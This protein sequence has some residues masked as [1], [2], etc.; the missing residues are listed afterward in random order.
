VWHIEI[1]EETPEICKEA[2]LREEVTV[3]SVPS[4]ISLI[5]KMLFQQLSKIARRG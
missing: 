5:L 4:D 3:K 1:Y 2:V